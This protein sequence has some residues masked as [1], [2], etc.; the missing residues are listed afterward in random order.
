MATWMSG[1][2][3]RHGWL[4]A[5]LGGLAG[6]QGEISVDLTAEPSGDVGIVRVIVGLKGAEFRKEDGTTETLEFR[7]AESIDLVELQNGDLITLFTDEELPE[8]VYKGIRLLFDTDPDLHFVVDDNGDR[9]VLNPVQGNYAAMDFTVEEDET[10]REALTLTLDIRQS[11]SYDDGSEEFTLQPVLRSVPTDEASVIAGAAAVNCPSG[12]SLLEGGA[13][14]LFQGEDVVPD[15]RDGIG[16][17][18][19][20]TVSLDANLLTGEFSYTLLDLP[21]GDYT[22][23]VTCRGDEEDP[24]V[25]DSLEF[26]AMTSVQ[27]VEEETLTVDLND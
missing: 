6:C 3:V 26:A 7:D 4:L 19:Y 9:F 1:R 13:V 14:Y 21:A 8:G 27:L 23:A 2:G 24:T 10:S 16:T 20:S 22:L 17:E 11:L 15:D 12:T 18:P 5:A 25:N